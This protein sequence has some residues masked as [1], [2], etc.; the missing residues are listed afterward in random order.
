M[1]RGALILAAIVAIAGAAMLA[2]PG[3]RSDARDQAPAVNARCPILGKK[4]NPDSVPASLTREFK[5]QK[6]GFCCGG[7]PGAW[8]KLTDAEKEA[9]LNTGR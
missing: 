3:C 6:V 7:C 5:G 2:P 8:D 4:I 1:K 9:K